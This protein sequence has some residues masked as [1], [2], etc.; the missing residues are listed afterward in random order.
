MWILS[1]RCRLN[2]ISLVSQTILDGCKSWWASYGTCVSL[3]LWSIFFSA[4]KTPHSLSLR[5][6]DFAHQICTCMISYDYTVSLVVLPKLPSLSSNADKLRTLDQAFFSTSV[7][8]AEHQVKRC[9]HTV[10]VT[11][12]WQTPFFSTG[13][14]VWVGQST[15]VSKFPS[16]FNP[17]K[18]SVTFEVY[19]LLYLRRNTRVL[20]SLF[21]PIPA[22]IVQ[23]WVVRREHRK[24]SSINFTHSG[25]LLRL[26]VV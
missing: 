24:L 5:L 11:R 2:H 19:D 18:L 16:S 6:V 7:F 14:W 10:L 23:L 26:E 3:C 1:W 4:D 13:H 25:K 8:N 21:K 15:I 22:V 12:C 9:L 20:L 17:W